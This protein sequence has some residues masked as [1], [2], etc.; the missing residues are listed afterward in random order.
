M[1]FSSLPLEGEIAEAVVCCG[2]DDRVALS[3]AALKQTT[4][5][6]RSTGSVWSNAQQNKLAPQR[7]PLTTIYSINP[8]TL[9]HLF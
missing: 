8:V 9:L 5:E 2:G 3:G 4:L 6:Q 7:S 1:L